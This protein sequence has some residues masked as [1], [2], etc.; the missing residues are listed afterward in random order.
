MS[1]LADFSALHHL[2]APGTFGVYGCYAQRAACLSYDV[3]RLGAVLQHY[4]SAHPWV[5]EVL[6]VTSLQDEHKNTVYKTSEPTAPKPSCSERAG[7][8]L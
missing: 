3:G 4:L 7:Q 6:Q 8:S 5:A 2:S 1:H